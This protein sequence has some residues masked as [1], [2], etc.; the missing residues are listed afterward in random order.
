M[1]FEAYL[2]AI[3]KN[4][5]SSHDV[6]RDFAADGRIWPAYARYESFSEKYV[7][8]RK[9][10][11]WSVREYEHVLFARA[12]DSTEKQVRALEAV[13]AEYMEP[14]LVRGG[15]S[16]PEKDHMRSFLT[17]VLICEGVISED[18]VRRVRKYHFDRG[19]RFSL[20]GFVQGRIVLI[21]LPGRRVVA[22]PGAKDIRKFYQRVFDEADSA[23]STRK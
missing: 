8:S 5:C 3:L 13:A 19:Y 6:E 1:D 21:D 18:A 11:L 9:A 10:S 15:K 23:F 16:V 20:R 2:N 17:L 14:V 4:M 7:L 22:S 12:A